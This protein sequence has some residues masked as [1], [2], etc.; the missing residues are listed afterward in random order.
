M[1]KSPRSQPEPRSNDVLQ[2]DDRTRQ[3]DASDPA[4]RA[5]AIP[6]ASST[7]QPRRPLP[8]FA[9]APRK[10]RPRPRR[11]EQREHTHELR[12]SLLCSAGI[13]LGVRR[14]ATGKSHSRSPSPNLDAEA[15]PFC[16]STRVA[17][18]PVVQP[19]VCLH[20]AFHHPWRFT[21]G[22]ARTGPRF[23]HRHS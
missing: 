20:L 17:C 1:G 23:V 3:P 7:F 4:R 5:A 19:A 11:E 9:Q 2:T 15:A 8:E 12:L 18:S 6:S 13:I 10:P 21:Y 22:S 16:G 14:D